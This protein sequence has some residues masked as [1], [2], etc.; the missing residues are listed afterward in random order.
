MNKVFDEPYI[1]LAAEVKYPDGEYQKVEVTSNKWDANGDDVKD[2]LFQLLGGLGFA[3]ATINKIFG[4][5]CV[6]YSELLPDD[7]EWREREP[8]RYEDI[9]ED[10]WQSFSDP[11]EGCEEGCSDTACLHEEPYDEV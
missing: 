10:V 11:C 6:C 4:D 5:D 8:D 2:L 7:S 1:R 9:S 3:E